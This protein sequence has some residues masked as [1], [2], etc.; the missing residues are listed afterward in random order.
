[1]TETVSS[2]VLETYVWGHGQPNRRFADGDLGR[3]LVG[4]GIDHSDGIRIGRYHE[5]LRAGS[6]DTGDGRW[7][8]HETCEG[9]RGE[10]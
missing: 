2:P 4:S 9:E 6:R 3:D 1:M 8:K 10:K 7:R 5:E